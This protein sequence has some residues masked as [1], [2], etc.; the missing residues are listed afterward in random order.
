MISGRN[1]QQSSMSGPGPLSGSDRGVRILPGGNGMGMM[2]GINRSIAMSRPGFQGTGSSSMLSSGG[3][4]SSSMVGMP[5]P[6]N[7]HSGVGAGPGN[8]LLRPREALH[9]M[10]VRSVVIPELNIS[11]QHSILDF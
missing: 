7:V 10:R 5:S 6:V 4:I 1:M 9:M 3:M 2:G 8:S 11:I